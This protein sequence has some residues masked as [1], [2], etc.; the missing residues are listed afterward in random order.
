MPV[1][2]LKTYTSE[3]GSVYQYYFV[4]K[5]EALPGDPY[6]PATEYVFDVSSDRK[7][8][9]A[10]SIF[11]HENAVGTW[12]QQHERGL[13]DAEKYAAAKMKLLRA[14]DEIADLLRDG[15]RLLVG[16]EDLELLLRQVGVE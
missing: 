8:T 12:E 11:L 16:A 4:G 3:T 10:V 1:R 6:S 9:F 15:R 5:R 7:V 13:V 2:R 14:F